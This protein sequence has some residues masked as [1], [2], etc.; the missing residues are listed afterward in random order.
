MI[1]K[2]EAEYKGTVCRLLG[3]DAPRGR[4]PVRVAGGRHP[5]D[6][7]ADDVPL[8]RGRAP[9]HRRDLPARA[10]GRQH[11]YVEIWLEKEALA[12]VLVD[13]TDQWDVPLMVTRGYPSIS[14]LHSAAEAIGARQAEAAHAIY[15][16]GDRDPS[17]VDIDRAVVQGIAG[18]AVGY[19]QTTEEVEP[20]LW[21]ADFERVAVTADQILDWELPPG[22]PRSPTAVQGLQGRERRGRRDPVR[23][24]ASVGRRLRRGTRRPTGDPKYSRPPKPRSGGS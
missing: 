12:G 4:D 14:F 18:I 1:A 7:E 16:F 24:A 8:G 11:G 21:Y 20:V 3:R 13:V 17:G 2:T 5:L 23:D 22:R 15:Y 10:L 9:E 19:P 6:A